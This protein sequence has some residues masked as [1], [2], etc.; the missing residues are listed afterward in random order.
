[1][2]SDNK[3][4][5]G[6]CVPAMTSAETELFLEYISAAPVYVEF[7]CGGSTCLAAVTP[8]VQRIYSVE[9]DKA[10]ITQV[11][12][13]PSVQQRLTEQT[14]FFHH[15]D[16]GATKKWGHPVSEVPHAD[17]ARYYWGAWQHL[18]A[19]ADF[20]FVDGRFR[21]ATALASLLAL[22]GDHYHIGVHD[23][24]NRPEYHVLEQFLITVR[25]VDTLTVFVPKPGYDVR[26]VFL[27][28]Q[29][30]AWTPA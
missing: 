28:L 10:W 24:T 9:S 27:T 21:V 3:Q 12:Q 14:L 8:S 1:M 20:I 2:K 26:T 25:V 13:T 4:T 23:Y 18:P 17:W 19:Y 6:D 11:M 30:Y 7:G 29:K 5:L 16:I 15:A 22:R